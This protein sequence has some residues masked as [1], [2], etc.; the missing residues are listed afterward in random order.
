MST[1]RLVAGMCLA[2]VLSM[3]G[4][5]TFPA[6]LPTLQAEWAL[7]NT[8]AGWLNGIVL[9]GYVAAVPLLVALTDRIDARRVYFVGLALSTLGLAGFAGAATGFWSALLWIC[10]QGMGIGGT[11]MTGL[12]AMADRA[13]GTLPSRAVALYTASFSIGTALSFVGAEA[14]GGAFGWETAFAVAAGGPLLAMLVAWAVLAPR[15]PD[16]SERPPTHLFDYRPVLRNRPAMSY[17]LGYAGHSWELFALRGWIVAFLVAAGASRAG[18]SGLGAATLAGAINLV[19]VLASLGG[20]ELAARYGRRRVIARV[21]VLSFIAACVAGATV[22]APLAVAVAAVTIHSCFVMGD[23]GALTAGAIGAAQPAYRGTTV[24][25]HAI[26]GFTAG[27][28][29]PVAV[30]LALDAAGGQAEPAAWFAAFA[31]MGA[32]SLAGG[33]ALVRMGRGSGDAPEHARRP[34]A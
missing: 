33:I 2:H 6:L 8:A 31:V 12:K 17:I 10:L 14:I 11:Y 22:S 16:A 19:V 9:G 13:A 5:A 29:G 7:S 28:L 30:G 18:E 25:L 24:A 4:F 32:G 15:R 1:A 34:A 23:S 3:T 20:N 21:M 27:W 26:L